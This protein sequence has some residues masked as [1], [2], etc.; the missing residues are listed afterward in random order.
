MWSSPPYSLLV[1]LNENS[2]KYVVLLE[3]LLNGV[4]SNHYGPG[5]W[6]WQL[7][8]LYWV[9]T[10]MKQVWQTTQYNSGLLR[11]DIFWPLS[12]GNGKGGQIKRKLIN[13]ITNIWENAKKYKNNIFLGNL[14]IM[15]RSVQTITEII[16]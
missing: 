1:F 11:V 2:R 8:V 9:H 5:H 10:I 4:G 12:P 13:Y 3:T 14:D 6:K 15:N 16:L 7:L